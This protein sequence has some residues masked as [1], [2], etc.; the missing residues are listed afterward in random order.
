[1]RQD[2]S[3]HERSSLIKEKCTN[4]L[5]SKWHISFEADRKKTP[6]VLLQI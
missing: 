5:L 3:F 6:K 2:A 1:M 4:E